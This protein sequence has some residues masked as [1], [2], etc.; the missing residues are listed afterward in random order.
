M[1]WYLCYIVNPGR[2]AYFPSLLYLF[3]HISLAQNCQKFFLD[4][5]KKVTDSKSMTLHEKKEASAAIQQAQKIVHTNRRNGKKYNTVTNALRP[6]VKV[7]HMM[8]AVR[9]QHLR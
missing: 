8:W 1:F 6:Y 3:S 2:L 5:A 7:Y 9:Q 4:A